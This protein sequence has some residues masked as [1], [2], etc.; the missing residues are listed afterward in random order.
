[1]QY[2]ALIFGIVLNAAA[3]IMIK[4][5][6][7]NLTDANVSADFLV[8]AIAQPALIGG[9]VAFGLALVS[10]S[11]AL[12]KIDLSIG[13]PVMTSVGLLLVVGYSA[14]YFHEHIGVMRISGIALILLGVV[15]IFRSGDTA[16]KESPRLPA[17]AGANVVSENPER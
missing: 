15:M 7:R 16:S 1:M 14:L 10:Y 8:R 4:A 17:G 6:M 12:T 11:F 3:N 9:L 5:A 2:I 13:Y